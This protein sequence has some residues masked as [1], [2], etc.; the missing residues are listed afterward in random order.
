MFNKNVTF[1]AVVDN[2]ETGV[3][4]VEVTISLSEIYLV[5]SIKGS[6]D[7]Y[8]AEKNNGSGGWELT[9]NTYADLLARKNPKNLI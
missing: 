3:F 2:E 1:K 5:H 8:F 9:L 4:E 6:V 7:R